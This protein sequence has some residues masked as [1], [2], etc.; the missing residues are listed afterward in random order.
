MPFSSIFKT[1]EIC[2]ESSCRVNKK[3]IKK[4]FKP[5]NGFK[6]SQIEK[7]LFP[8]D[9]KICDCIIICKDN[10]IVIVEI[11]CGTLTYKEFKEKIEQLKNCYTVVKTMGLEDKIKQITL[12]YKKREKDKKNP[13]FAKKLLNPKIY[14]KHLHLMQNEMLNIDC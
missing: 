6:D 11:L 4:V 7:K 14:N 9:Y 2:K 10:S 13:Q 5:D 8:N 3:N 12:Q 1:V